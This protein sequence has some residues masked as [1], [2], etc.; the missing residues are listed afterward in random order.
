MT[1][2]AAARRQ[3]VTCEASG[4][5]FAL[6]VFGV[7]RVLRYSAPSRLPNSAA[8]L[9]GV[10]TIVGRLVPV[11]DLRERLGLAAPPPDDRARIVVVTLEDGPMGLIVDRVHDVVQVDATDIEEAPGV[12]RGL[13]R[14]YVAGIV[15]RGA[16][17]FVL[18]DVERLV[19]STERISMREAVSREL[20][21]GG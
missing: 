12:Y 2:T 5:R 8:W 19:T 3:L 11:L 6:D 21:H 15:R 13:A 9:P 17:V 7:E 18:L 4:E 1:S 10:V 14:E 20:D 16:G